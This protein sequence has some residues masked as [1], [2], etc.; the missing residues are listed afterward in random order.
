ML[1]HDLDQQRQ[2]F[3]PELQQLLDELKSLREPPDRACVRGKISGVYR[4]YRAELV[5]IITVWAIAQTPGAEPTKFLVTR[6]QK[7]TFGH[8]LSNSR[9]AGLWCDPQRGAGERGALPISERVTEHA[10]AVFELYREALDRPLDAEQLEQ[11]S[12][13]LLESDLGL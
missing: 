11:L 10:S 2:R 4:R 6:W 9:L 7:D 1:L 12:A 5:A 3:Y 13:V 8:A